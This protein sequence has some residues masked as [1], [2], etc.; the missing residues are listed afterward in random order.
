MDSHKSNELFAT[1]DIQV[2]ASYQNGFR[3]KIYIIWE[4]G[5][6]S[7]IL[8][9]MKVKM[10]AIMLQSLAKLSSGFYFLLADFQ[11]WFI[12]FINIGGMLFISLLSNT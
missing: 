8:F 9:K 5:L 3:R 2:K 7:L 4:V 10:Q 12:C 11:F 6:C 1:G